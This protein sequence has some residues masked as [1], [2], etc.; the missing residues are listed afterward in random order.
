MNIETK[1]IRELKYE[2]WGFEQIN[3]AFLHSLSRLI[4]IIE[5]DFRYLQYNKEP[6]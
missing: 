4:I 3:Q 6:I 5:N 2:K 1:G